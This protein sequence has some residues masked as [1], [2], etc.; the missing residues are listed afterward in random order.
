MIICWCQLMTS[1]SSFA[2]TIRLDTTFPSRASNSD[3]VVSLLSV[4]FYTSTHNHRTDYAHSS[5]FLTHPENS[6]THCMP[7]AETLR[8]HLPSRAK[9]VTSFHRPIVLITSPKKGDAKYAKKSQSNSKF[10]TLVPVTEPPMPE[11]LSLLRTR[12]NHAA[13]LDYSRP[14]DWDE[15]RI[16]A[17]LFENGFSIP[18][19]DASTPWVTIAGRD[20]KTTVLP[21]GYRTPLLFAVKFQWDSLRLVMTSAARNKEWEEYKYDILHVSRLCARFLADARSALGAAGIDRG[22]RSTMFDRALTR[23]Y[24]RWLVNR[25]EFLKDFWCLFGE[26]EYERDVLKNG[27]FRLPLQFRH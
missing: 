10:T 23:Y 20:G 19:R 27:T 21:R 24:R 8:I 17:Y 18:A 4:L 2:P 25:P 7:K 15:R 5:K 13:E 11:D 1:S 6:R 3:R 26:V 12:W 16:I 14:T 22:W 9:D